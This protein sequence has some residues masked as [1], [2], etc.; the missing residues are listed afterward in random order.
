MYLLENVLGAGGVW[1]MMG[2][3]W[4]Q[5]TH[6]AGKGEG[7]LWRGVSL[8]PHPGWWLAVLKMD[9]QVSGLG[10]KV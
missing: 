10:Q 4:R 3:G 1:F 6:G 8:G 9:T 2:D 5:R 7:S